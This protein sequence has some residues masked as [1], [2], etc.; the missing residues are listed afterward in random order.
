MRM[1][2]SM[3]PDP[4]SLKALVVIIAGHGFIPEWGQSPLHA[5]RNVTIE[6]VRRLHNGSD[7][8]RSA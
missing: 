5:L 4:A 8:N 1:P 7:N 3:M 2:Y 6:V